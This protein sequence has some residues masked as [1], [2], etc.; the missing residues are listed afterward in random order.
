MNIYWMKYSPLESNVSSTDP[1]ALDYMAQQLGYLP[2]PNFTGRTSRARYYSMVCY[3]LFICEEKIKRD[4]LIFNDSTI[5]KLFEL[6][7]KY[8]AYAV[9]S[10]YREDIKERDSNESG[11]RGKRGAIKAVNNNKIKSLGDEYRLLSRQLELGGLGAYR[12]SLERFGLIKQSSLS[13]TMKGHE[14]AE[15]FLPVEDRMRKQYDELLIESITDQTIVKKR[16]TASIQKFGE[17][18]CLDFYTRCERDPKDRSLLRKHI[19]ESE[20]ITHA[21]AIL[22]VPLRDTW[23]SSVLSFFEEISAIQT[24]DPSEG[25]VRD[26]FKTIYYFELLSIEL[27]NVFCSV[28]KAAYENG[29]TITMTELKDSVEKIL[30]G[31]YTRNLASMLAESPKFFEMSGY[32]YGTEFFGLIS[33]IMAGIGY[34]QFIRAIMKLHGEVESKR[35]SATWL[36]I[37]GESIVY[38]TGY[39]YAKANMNRHHLF[40]I[41]N[42]FSIIDDLGWQA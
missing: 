35:N 5:M 4:N 6:F 20:A 21:T 14:L 32:F 33:S 40:K 31:I 27:N 11:L 7:E 23:G 9:I 2:L 25:Y 18:A 15:N 30:S 37:E 3:G 29:G 8:W 13:L 42:L 24:M 34:E 19:M 22:A 16:G 10:F 28:I 12:S 41:P 38:C 1:L 36:D 26:S 39:E 17:Y